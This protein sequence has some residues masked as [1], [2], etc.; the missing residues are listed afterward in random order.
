MSEIP[1][2]ELYNILHRKE[3]KDIKIAKLLKNDYLNT[4]SFGGGFAAGFL[5]QIGKT[6][7]VLPSE[8]RDA[9]LYLPTLLQAVIYGAVGTVYGLFVGAKE[10]YSASEGDGLVSKIAKTT[11]GSVGGAAVGASV[12]SVIGGMKGGLVTLFGYGVGRLA[13]L[14]YKA[15]K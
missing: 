10:A 12:S 13:G 8:A 1:N 5:D 7:S 6:H 14:L 4:V 11:A 15:F 2:S 3:Q 9:L